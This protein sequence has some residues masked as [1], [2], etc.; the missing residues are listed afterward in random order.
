MSLGLSGGRRIVGRQALDDP[1]AELVAG[2]ETR[3]LHEGSVEDAGGTADHET[4]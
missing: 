3:D 4:R 2:G 1:V